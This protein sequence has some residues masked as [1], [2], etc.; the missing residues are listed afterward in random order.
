MIVQRFHRTVGIGRIATAFRRHSRIIGQ[1]RPGFDELGKKPKDRD[2][3]GQA[4]DELHELQ[5]N[6]STSVC[7]AVA[8]QNMTWEL[9]DFQ[10]ASS[11]SGRFENLVHFELNFVHAL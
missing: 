4:S 5:A 2:K 8:P 3:A 10:P 1:H 6:P 7:Q 9:E 11:K